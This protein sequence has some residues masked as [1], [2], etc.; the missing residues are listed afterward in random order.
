MKSKPYIRISRLRHCFLCSGFA[1]VGSGDTMRE[2]WESWR[3]EM[4]R[5]WR[6][7]KVPGIKSRQENG[8]EAQGKTI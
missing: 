6:G 2:A 7:K 3:D 8:H 1:T 4:V 5:Y